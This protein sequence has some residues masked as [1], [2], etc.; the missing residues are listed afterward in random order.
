MTLTWMCQCCKDTRPDHKIGVLTGIRWF[1]DVEMQFNVK[2]CKD[3]PGCIA[4][5]ALKVAEWESSGAQGS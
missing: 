1:D 3:R 5:A 2:F 4:L